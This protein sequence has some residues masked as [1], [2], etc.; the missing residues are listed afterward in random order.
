VRR[1]GTLTLR[2]EDGRVVC[3]SC[4]IADSTLRRMRGLLG[5]SALKPGEGIVLRPAWSIHTGFMRFPIDAVFLDPDLT[6]IHIEPELRPWKTASV[7]GSRE[8]VELR[9]GE[10]ERRG[11]EVG[12]RVA[13]ASVAH[14]LLEGAPLPAYDP[15]AARVVV[16]SRDKRFSK[17][18]RFLL[19]RHGVASEV[20]SGHDLVAIIE[21]KDAT[22]V[23]LDASESLVEAARAVAAARALHPRVEIVVVSDDL[24]DDERHDF[25]VHDKWEGMDGV[26]ERV[27]H[28]LGVAPAA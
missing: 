27:S 28:A 18:M 12:D 22:L 26:V 1:R 4:R 2:R 20:A 15:A 10:C 11:L 17:V 5:R 25:P 13:W 23:V 8:I 6:V 14:D 19:E 16:A 9:A 24:A 7:R 3:E 21:Q